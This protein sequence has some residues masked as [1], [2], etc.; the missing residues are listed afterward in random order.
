MAVGSSYTST[1]TVASGNS[2][3]VEGSSSGTGAVEINELGG[4]GSA[5][6]FKEIDTDGDGTYELSFRL[7]AISGQ[8]HSQKNKLIVSAKNNE[9]LR[10][11]ND[12]DVQQSYYAN[13]MEVED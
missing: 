4:T 8:W 5:T 12:S 11:R 2:T 13:G 1:G 7:D 3:Y 9:R 10:I 6:I